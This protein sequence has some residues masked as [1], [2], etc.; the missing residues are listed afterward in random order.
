MIIAID[1]PAAPGKSTVA[2]RVATALGVAFLDTGAMYRAVTH[3]VLS[4]DLD[5][6]DEVACGEVAESLQLGFTSAGEIL[7][8]GVPGEPHIRGPRID[9]VVS[10]VA[11]HPRVR[12]AIVT[13]QKSMGERQSLVAEGRDTTTVVFPGADHKFF[14]VASA[15]ERGRRRAEQEGFPGRA[16]LYADE[17]IRRDE[18]DS[19]REHSPL[20]QATDATRIETDKLSADEVVD[21]V[22]SWIRK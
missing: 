22:L 16:L 11:A 6:A 1:G 21:L 20:R 17:L 18:M 5:P 7:I 2:R 3:E 4:R 8:D 15:A 13:I 14:L 9:G 19:S 10:T 12:L